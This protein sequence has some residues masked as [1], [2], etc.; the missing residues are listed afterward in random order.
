MTIFI[1]LKTNRWKA[2]LDL[3]FSKYW[4]DRL[5]GFVDK[6]FDMFISIMWKSTIRSKTKQIMNKILFWESTIC[7]K[8]KQIINLKFVSDYNI[9]S[10]ID[11]ENSD[12]WGNKIS[13]FEYDDQWRSI[14]VSE[15]L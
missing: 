3:Q 4:S 14:S 8:T 15:H 12:F 7:S 9:F 2:P 6:K 11:F 10:K 13:W 5:F 1:L